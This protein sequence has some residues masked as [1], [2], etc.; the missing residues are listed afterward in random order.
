MAAFLVVFLSNLFLLQRTFFKRALSSSE[1]WS[2]L[3]IFLGFPC[4]LL[5]CRSLHTS[6]QLCFIFYISWLLFFI[7]NSPDF[8]TA[9]SSM[10]DK[11]TWLICS[12]KEV[13]SFCFGPDF[14]EIPSLLVR[15]QNSDLSVSLILLNKQLVLFKVFFTLYD[16]FICLFSL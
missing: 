15:S 11:S 2:T 4:H 1:T 16:T 9:S 3:M 7:I 10:D 8:T 5:S 12:Y 6:Q 14:F 13:D